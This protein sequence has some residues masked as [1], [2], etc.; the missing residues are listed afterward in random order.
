M[1]SNLLS[2]K[3]QGSTKIIIIVVLVVFI[4]IASGLGAAL[5]LLKSNQA[6]EPVQQAQ[7]DST[8]PQ[9]KKDNISTGKPS[10][11]KMLPAFVVNLSSGTK[12]HFLQVE[13]Q[14]MAN[15]DSAIED[16]MVYE[17]LIKNHLITLFAAQKIHEIRTAEGKEKLRSEATAL[18][19][20]VMS[21][22]TGD[23]TIEEVLF[24][25]FVTQ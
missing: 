16:V 15:N 23:E 22:S 21:D 5:F 1:Q 14:V 8:E 18:V 3:Q 20:K 13:V 10:F 19:K 6:S 7:A 9:E 12:P 11:Y 25:G 24:T 4:S 2:K 17:P